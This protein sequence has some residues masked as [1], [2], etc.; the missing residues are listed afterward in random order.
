M[1]FIKKYKVALSLFTGLIV[2]SILTY[3]LLLWYN[4]ELSTDFSG[5]RSYDECW[6]AG[7]TTYQNADRQITCVLP[8]GKYFTHTML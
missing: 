3:G 7:F 8:N 6:L 5:I 2:G 4:P 1:N